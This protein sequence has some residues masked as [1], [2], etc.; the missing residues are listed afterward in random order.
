LV[1]PRGWIG[2]PVEGLLPIVFYFAGLGHH[3]GLKREGLVANLKKAASVPFVLVAPLRPEGIWW[4]ISDDREW[5]WVDGDF[6]PDEV[7][8]LVLW[9]CALAL[10]PG[11]DGNNVAALGFSAGAYCVTELMAHKCT[12]LC[13][14]LIGGV[15]GH[16]HPGLHGL[17]GTKRSLRKWNAY[18]KRLQNGPGMT[19]CILGV[20]DTG[21]TY[22]AWGNAAD[23]FE[24]LDNRQRYKGLPHVE[25]HDAGRLTWWRDTNLH[26]YHDATIY[27]EEFLARLMP[28]VFSMT[29]P[30][31]PPA[32]WE[33][34]QS[35]RHGWGLALVH[36][37]N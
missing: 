17:S 14:V 23:I 12:P 6:L 18:I 8:R 5:G 30:P 10:Q 15:H 27:R 20:H 28:S 7:D 24:A 21:D 16:G 19:R 2:S 35:R 13:G 37:V 25:V 26:N 9:M 29:S 1:T 34:S 11:I 31:A 3:G 22:C 32:H 36:I 4:T 33:D